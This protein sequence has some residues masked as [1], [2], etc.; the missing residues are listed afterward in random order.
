MKAKVTILLLC[1]L[2]LSPVAALAEIPDQV[3]AP[4]VDMTLWPTPSL[5]DIYQE[6]GQKYFTLAFITQ[7]D[8]CTPAWAGTS[9]LDMDS[10]QDEIAELRA[11]GGDIIISFGGAN[12]TELALG[13]E[14]EDSLLAAYQEVIDAYSLT[15][16]DFDIEGAAVAD[17]ESIDRRSSVIRQLQINNPDLRVAFCL[18][19][20]P[21]GL[22]NDGLYVLESAIDAGVEIDV[23]NV[24]AMDYGD[25]AAPDPDG[26]MGAYAIQAAESTYAQ[27]EA[28]GLDAKIGVTP[29][30]GQNDVSTEIFYLTDASQLLSWAQSS[31]YVTL[32]SMWSVGRDNGDC[33]TGTLSSAC[34]GLEI[35]DYAFTNIFGNYT[36]SGS[37]GNTWPTVSITSP[38]DEEVFGDEPDITIEANAADSDGTIVQVE[39][40]AD[41]ESLGV[42]TESPYSVVWEGVATGSYDLTAA[43]T[44]DQGA[45]VTSTIVTIW[46]GS[47]VCTADAW[48]ESETYTAGDTVSYNGHEWQAKWWTEGDEPDSSDEWGVWEDLGAC[49]SSDDDDDDSGESGDDEDGNELPTV[50][51][52]APADGA[53][54]AYGDT[55][56]I[57]ATATDSD[58]SIA[59]VEF[60]YN[61]TSLGTDTES[62]YSIEWSGAAVG[63]YELTA[64]A[65][66]NEGGSTESSSVSIEITQD[67]E[68]SGDDD[69]LSC[70][71]LYDYPEGI[72]S[73][74]YG[75]QV[76]NN[77]YI[78]E[79]REFP[80]GAWANIDAAAF[81]EPG[82]GSAWEDAWTLVGECSDN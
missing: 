57:T 63:E 10:Y 16:I 43:A 21:S 3:F 24:M 19:V 5:V 33:D 60:F 53:T 34:S 45:T 31:S 50:S 39:F 48:S 15:W 56:T 18:P 42:D 44:D 7:G 2:L 38:E 8:E 59:Q 32:L 46:V 74:D 68:E 69:E 70:E 14:D 81:Y 30:I 29:M 78:Y 17:T 23:V 66:D 27:M 11:A 64:V 1:L 82:V 28:L 77:G 51:I 58:G 80:Y 47:D 35:D 20:L 9:S 36:V 75:Q 49:G 22:T 71:G 37:D 72:G 25:S 52:S 6:T 67:G 40:F 13:C 4:Y 79:V 12:G 73:Y 61:G 41:G 55:I 54:Y 62:P 65:T 76:Q 26:Q